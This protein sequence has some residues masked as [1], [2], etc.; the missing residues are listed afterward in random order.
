M[1]VSYVATGL[2]LQAVGL[3]SQDRGSR[4]FLVGIGSPIVLA[5]LASYMSHLTASGRESM[6]KCLKGAMIGLLAAAYLHRI[7]SPQ[8]T[9]AQDLPLL[10]VTASG[11]AF[12][13]GRILP[14]T[15]RW[16]LR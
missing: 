1:S 12:L 7:A 13:A 14:L 11:T 4:F 3:C 10:A 8:N 15:Q 16:C 9:F 6:Q 5:G 2:W